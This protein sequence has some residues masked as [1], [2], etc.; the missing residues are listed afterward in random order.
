MQAKNLT[1]CQI[2]RCLL[3]ICVKQ[4]LQQTSNVENAIAK[5]LRFHGMMLCRIKVFCPL[6][7]GHFKHGGGCF[8]FYYVNKG[9]IIIAATAFTLNNFA[10][11]QYN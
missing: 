2:A 4:Y 5:N 1:K 7:F 8:K 6:A 3:Q 10:K 9:Y 11:L